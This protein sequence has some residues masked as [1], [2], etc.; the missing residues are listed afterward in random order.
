MSEKFRGPDIPGMS[1]VE[2]D[3]EFLLDA[4]VDDLLI[5]AKDE[6]L[7]IDKSK[8]AKKQTIDSLQNYINSL[9]QIIKDK[10]ITKEVVDSFFD[11]YLPRAI[12]N[13]SEEC[14]EF[15]LRLA[16]ALSVEIQKKMDDQAEEK[17]K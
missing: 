7:E 5:N 12:N 6:G 15:K 14:Y 17:N 10:K 11:N 3:R 4:P 13:P 9:R 16:N 8:G 2:I 1:T